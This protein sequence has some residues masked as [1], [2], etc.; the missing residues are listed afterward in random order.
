LE[1][2]LKMGF[3]VDGSAG[4][5]ESG[6]FTRESGSYELSHPDGTCLAVPY[7]AEFTFGKPKMDRKATRR[8]K[9]RR[10]H[11]E[12]YTADG[13][14]RR[15]SGDFPDPIIVSKKDSLRVVTDVTTFV[16]KNEVQVVTKGHIF[17][18]DIARELVRDCVPIGSRAA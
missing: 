12:K 17:V 16:T 18:I 11:P 15:K 5:E 2:A 8:A 10:E 4:N 9:D 1:E 7:R 6:D 14:L 3:Q 13:G